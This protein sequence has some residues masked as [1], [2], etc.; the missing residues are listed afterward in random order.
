MTRRLSLCVYC[1]SRTG[2]QPAYRGRGARGRQRRSARRGWQLVYGGGRVGLMGVVA[3]AA[4]AAGAPVR[5]R[6]PAVADGARGRPPRPDRTARRRDHARAQADDG[7]AQRRLRRAARR[8]RHLRRTVRGL[9]LAPARLPRQAGRPAQRRRL[10]R[11]AARLHAADGRAAASCRTRSMHL[12][13]VHRRRR[14]TCSMRLARLTPLAT[15]PDDYRRICERRRSA[16]RPRLRRSRRCGCAPPA[17]P[18]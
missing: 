9:D 18:R 13:Q 4:L 1:G 15:A 2:D 11:R 17:R 5:R 10:L 14:T 3:D 6:D 7:R 12:L 16:L 8:H